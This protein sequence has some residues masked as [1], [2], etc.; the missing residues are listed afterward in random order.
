MHYLVSFGRFWYDF[1]VGDEWRLAVGVVVIL[2]LTALIEYAG[3]PAWWFL[4]LAVGG[5]LSYVVRRAA[6]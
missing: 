4:L 6:K 3:V 5:L 1:I 2:C